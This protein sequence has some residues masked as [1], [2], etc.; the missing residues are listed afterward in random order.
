MMEEFTKEFLVATICCCSFERLSFRYFCGCL[1]SLCILKRYV[2]NFLS[3]RDQ[4]AFL[5]LEHV[6]L[7]A[8]EQGSIE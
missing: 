8:I 5:N 1:T 4:E 7:R 3:Q 2:D 6:I